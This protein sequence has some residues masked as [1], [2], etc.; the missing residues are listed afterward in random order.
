[1]LTNVVSAHTPVDT[2]RT[3]LWHKGYL[4]WHRHLC[5]CL[6]YS[7]KFITSLGVRELVMVIMLNELTHRM[8]GHS[9]SLLHTPVICDLWSHSTFLL[10]VRLSVECCRQA[11]NIVVDYEC[12]FTL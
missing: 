5:Q 2:S 6:C 4:G 11:C 12:K 9:E 7:V 10:I 3:F 8:C 1:M